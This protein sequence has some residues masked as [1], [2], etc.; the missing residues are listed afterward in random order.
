MRTSFLL[1]AI[2][3]SLSSALSQTTKPEPAQDI[4][5]AALKQA[6]TSDKTV[7]LIFHASWCSWCKKL[8]AVLQDG[9]VKKIMDAHYIITHL[10]VAESKDKKETHENPGGMEIA[11]SLGGDKSGLPYYAFLDIKGKKIVDSNV[12]PKNQNIGYPGSK[13]EIAAFGNLLRQSAPRMTDAERSTVI[14]CLEK[15]MP[16]P[17]LAQ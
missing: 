1:F 5:N 17:R 7:F 12:M 10:D 11:K 15:N 2:V 14:A 9:E 16:K 4:L 6:G 8:D 13:E 3:I